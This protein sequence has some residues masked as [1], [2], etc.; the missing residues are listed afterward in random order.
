ML[1]A[2]LFIAACTEEPEGFTINGTLTGEVENGTKVYLKRTD[3][4]KVPVDV[5]TT[6]VED[7]KFTFKGEADIP[8]LHYVFI[9]K[10]NGNIPVILEEGV[11]AVTAQKDSLNLAKIE[12]TTQNDLF[13][14]FLK[15]SR[16]ISKRAM[17]MTNDMREAS[18]ANDTAVM[19][20]LRDEYMELQTEARDFE[21]NFAK[22]H[23]NALISALIIDKAL[24]TKA[25]PDVE[26]KEM[27]EALT[28]EIKFTKVGVEINQRLETNKSTSIGSKAPNFSGPTPTGQE[29]A[30]HDVLG[31]ATIVDF[32][33]AWCKPCRAENPNVVKVYD[34]YK[35][36]GLSIVGVSLDRR[37]EDWKKAIADDGLEWHHVSNVQYFDEIAKLYNVNAIPATFILDAE[38]TIVAK[39]LRGPDLE[40]KI[41]E[42]LD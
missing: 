9:D 40:D 30:L 20:S 14:D 12:G 23:P 38:G 4:K 15:D 41:S 25:L 34:K 33:A 17:S 16:A 22:D 3:E 1:L 6:T 26:I 36:K 29:L 19:T 35:D 7:G 11:I 5:D 24:A 31:K 32:W 42:L 28:E 27:Y 13:T 21:L 39:D 10:I 8:E 2:F 37:A 18:T